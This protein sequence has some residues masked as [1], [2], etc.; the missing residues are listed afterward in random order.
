M[1][2][3]WLHGLCVALQMQPGRQLQ[4]NRQLGCPCLLQNA[5]SPACVQP[6]PALAVQVAEGCGALAVHV[7]PRYVLYNA[8]GQDVK[9]RQQVR[10]A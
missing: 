1:H 9:F 4:P 2:E 7:M 6:G 3:S 10:L 5:C 8:M